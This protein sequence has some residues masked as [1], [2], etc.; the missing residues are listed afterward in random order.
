MISNKLQDEQVDQ[1]PILHQNHLVVQFLVE[2]QVDIEVVNQ[3]VQELV[4]QNQIQKG[5]VN[6]ILLNLLLE[7][8]EGIEEE[9]LLCKN[10]EQYSLKSQQG[11]RFFCFFYDL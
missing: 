7:N 5:V 1:L 2:N 10:I 11:L 6:Q 9:I 4:H 8:Q 3:I